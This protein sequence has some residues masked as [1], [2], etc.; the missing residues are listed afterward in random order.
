MDRSALPLPPRRRTSFQPSAYSSRAFGASRAL[1]ALW[2]SHAALAART[3]ASGA[4]AWHCKPCMRD[5]QLRLH[6]QWVRAQFG[7]RDCPT[8]GMLPAAP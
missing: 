5:A 6:E 1:L 7:S 4:G 8:L 3:T 2:A